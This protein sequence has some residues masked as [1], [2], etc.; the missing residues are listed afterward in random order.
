MELKDTNMRQVIDHMQPCQLSQITIERT[1]QIRELECESERGWKD[2]GD[3]RRE[4]DVILPMPVH[5]RYGRPE[6][7]VPQRARA[8]QSGGNFADFTRQRHYLRSSR[9][10]EVQ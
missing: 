8:H 6:V 9:K 4:E 10:Y 3:Q 7:R 5:G 2:A 1:A